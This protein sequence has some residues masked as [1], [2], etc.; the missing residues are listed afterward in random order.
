MNSENENM[1]MT[2]QTWHMTLGQSKE[3]KEIGKPDQE[4]GLP[5]RPS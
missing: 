1:K 5:S 3:G 2:A 4:K